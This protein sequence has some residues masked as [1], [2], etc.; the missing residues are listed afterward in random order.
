MALCHRRLVY[1]VNLLQFMTMW[2]TVE[3]NLSVAI[4]S[5]SLLLN[6]MSLNLVWRQ[7]TAAT[8]LTND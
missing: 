8:G 6:S 7:L 5:Q 3:L 4:T 1:V 2:Q